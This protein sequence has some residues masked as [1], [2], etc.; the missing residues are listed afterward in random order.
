MTANQIA[1]AKLVEDQ[2]SHR[3]S[4]N[5]KG[6]ELGEIQRANRE[7]E[8][9]NWFNAE[10]QAQH[11][12]RMDQEQYRSNVAREAEN[13]RSHVAQEANQATANAIQ[14]QS[15]S[16]QNLHNFQ[17][18]LQGQQ[19]L[20]QDLKYNQDRITQGYVN[21]FADTATSL[22]GSFMRSNISG[23]GGSHSGKGQAFQIFE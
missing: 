18:E 19:K 12:G 2:R 17:M 11:Y 14:R 22:F 9:I 3:A 7:G 5:L 16:N 8:R 15:V 21:K 10:N 20:D 4:E 6:V 13:Y 23:K 1:Y